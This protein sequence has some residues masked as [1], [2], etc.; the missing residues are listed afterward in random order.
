MLISQKNTKFEKNKR[1][2]D[3]KLVESAYYKK[4][5]SKREKEKGD[6]L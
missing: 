3:K 5:D 4:N 1:S 2:S 6:K